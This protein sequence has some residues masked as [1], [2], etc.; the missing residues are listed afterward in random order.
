M[1]NE[2]LSVLLGNYATRLS[3]AIRSAEEQLPD[4]LFTGDAKPFETRKHCPALD[5]LEKL[6]D[7]LIDDLDTLAS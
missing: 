3:T 2:Q 4:E 5:E 6:R 7:R 1:T